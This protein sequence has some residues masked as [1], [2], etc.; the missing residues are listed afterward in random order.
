MYVFEF[1]YPRES[2]CYRRARRMACKGYRQKMTSW[3]DLQR[4]RD[5]TISS[6]TKH[7]RKK[8]AK[9]AKD[10]VKGGGKKI[11]SEDVRMGGVLVDE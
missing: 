4:I 10:P 7:E 5:V 3:G 11:D 8:K 6:K 1:G 2:S 9:Q